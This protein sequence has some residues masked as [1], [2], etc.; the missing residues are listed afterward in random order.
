MWPWEHVAFGYLLYSLATNIGLGESTRDRAM[1]AVCVAAVLP[2]LIDKPLAWTFEVFPSGYA[3]GHSIFVAPLLAVVA[4]A[5]SRRYGRTDVGVAFAVGYL[6][7][8]L[9]DVVYP[10][11]EGDPIAPEILLWPLV[12]LPSYEVQRGFL[13]RFAM[14]FGRWIVQLLSLEPSP[15]LVFEG[16]LALSVFVLWLYDG[17]PGLKWLVRSVVPQ[18]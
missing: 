12:E 3:L 14:Y 7:H 5:V 17:L 15:L 6:S 16:L 1:V 11:I 10:V 2:D 18:K 13:E 9:G 8:L 4:I